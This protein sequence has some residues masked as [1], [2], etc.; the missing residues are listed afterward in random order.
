MN[1]YLIQICLMAL[2]MLEIW[3]CY[4]FVARLVSPDARIPVW[5][6]LIGAVGTVV[7][8]LILAF[9]RHIL[10]F[11]DNVWTWT[12]IACCV[13]LVIIL[14]KNIIE[15]IELV[16]IYGSMIALLDFFYAYM[17]M[18]LLQEQF[19]NEVYFMAASGW[20]VLIYALTRICALIMVL[21]VRKFL[22]DNFPV[23]EC[24]TVFLLAAIGLCIL[25][26]FYNLLLWDLASA[27]PDVDIHVVCVSV[28]TI[29]AL[30]CVMMFLLF[31]GKVALREKDI[32]IIKN[33][34]QERQ[35][36]EVKAITEKNHG[37]VHDMKN[38]ILILRNLAKEEDLEG[39]NTYL[40]QMA[41]S[42]FVEID[43][44]W[45]GNQ[46]LDILLNQK[47]R[48]AIQEGI[49]FDIVSNGTVMLGLS[50]MELVSM[51]GNLLDNA[52]EACQKIPPGERKICVFLERKNDMVMIRVSNS[53]QNAPIIKEGE[54]L[55]S[56]EDRSSHG[57]GLKNVNAIVEKAGG[58][59]RYEYH[60]QTFVAQ[61]MFFDN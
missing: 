31:K 17:I 37:I 36:R 38:H 2:S 18:T 4:I 15:I 56:K 28:L 12:I 34:A 40:E 49:Q 13:W 32:L 60:N 39:I 26:R 46:V 30:I 57:Y 41:E 45:T 50:E 10:F 14:R 54:V 7:M 48:V 16:V 55:T 1:E 8:G 35:F 20:S 51:F 9:Y 61:I 22:P 25:V 21:F 52:I 3:M 59:I 43:Q 29:M 5:G 27:I 33:E 53:A 47:Q 11:A 44:K 19:W 24:R 58:Q 42:S 23:R 6:K